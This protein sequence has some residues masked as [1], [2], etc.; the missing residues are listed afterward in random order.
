MKASDLWVFCAR[1]NPLGWETPHR[2]YLEWVEHMLDSGVNLVVAEVQYGEREFECNV[3]PHIRHVG[4]RASTPAWSKEC[5]INQAIQRT[6]E[7]N[8][9]A[10]IDSDVFFEKAGWAAHVVEKLQLHHWIQPWSQAIDRGPNGEILSVFHSFCK[11]YL[12]G[13]QL[14]PD[15]HGWKSYGCDPYPHPG[16][17]HATTRRVLEHTEMLFEWGGMGAADHSMCLALVGQAEHAAPRNS[18]ARYIERLLRWQDRV[19]HAVHGSIG[20]AHNVVNHRF[21]GRKG[22]RKYLDRWESFTRHG[23]NPD[24]DLKR[25]SYGVLEWARNKPELEREWFLY[26]QSRQE[27]ANVT[28]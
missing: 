9:I 13:K 15:K 16:Y 5:A 8:Y 22:D 27:D 25:N 4:L 14:R 2:H 17:G 12:H 21:H 18:N 3:S 23:F 6:P 19:Q 11:Q 26:M 20:Y 24:E 28:E 1:Y 7:A 10:W